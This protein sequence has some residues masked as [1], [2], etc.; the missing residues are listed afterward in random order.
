MHQPPQGY[1]H[2]AAT[3][4]ALMKAVLELREAVTRRIREAQ[5]LPLPAAKLCAHSRNEQIGCTRLHRRLLGTPSAATRRARARPR[6]RAPAGPVRAPSASSS[7]PHLCVGCGACSTVCPS[8]AMGFSYP[9]PADQGKRCA[10]CSRPTPHAGGS[11]A[12]LLLHSE[13][14]GAKRL[15]DDLG[16]AART[17][18]QRQRRAGA[19]AAG[20]AVAHRQR[21]PGP[22]AGGH[23]QGASQVWVLLSDEEAPEYRQALAEQMAVAQ[24][25]LSGL[26]YAGEHFRLIEARDARDLAALDAALRAPAARTVA[27]PAGFATQADKRA[28]LDLALDHLLAQAPAA[29]RRDRPAGRR[30]ALRQPAVDT[31][32]VHDVPELRR[33]LPRERAGRQ[34]RASRS[35]ASSRRTACSAACAPP[36]APSRPSRCSRGCGWPTAARRARPACA[37]RDGALPLRALRKPFGTLRAIENMI[38]K[39]AGHAPSR[40]R[41]PSG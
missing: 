7:E 30:R 1:F 40:A 22:V 18:R 20:G 4:R 28:T 19:C 8:G 32:Q 21:R 14:A 33:R 26:G 41:R 38:G 31:E 27:R 16:R 24:A 10:R 37:A 15:I 36:P 5:V 35:C 39:L 9:G 34:P 11:D 13:G 3:M 2:V 6:P 23:R 25:I 29:R 17:D 12:A